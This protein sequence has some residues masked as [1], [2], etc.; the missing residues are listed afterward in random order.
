[1][2]AKKKCQY[3]G[4]MFGDEV[5]GNCPNCGGNEWEFVEFAYIEPNMNVI[6]LKE[7]LTKC[8]CEQRQN[9]QTSILQGILLKSAIE[10]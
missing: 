9:M 1:M 4:S 5:K 6:N 7:E 10:R 3:C 8:M 2:L